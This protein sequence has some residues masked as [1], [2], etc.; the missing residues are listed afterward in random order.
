M[1]QMTRSERL[2]NMIESLVYG[3]TEV[4]DFVHKMAVDQMK[5]KYGWSQYITDVTIVYTQ[6]EYSEVMQRTTSMPVMEGTE[7]EK[8]YFSL[9]SD[10]LR[11]ALA[12]VID[13]GACWDVERQQIDV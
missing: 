11:K 10:F 9:M 7:K 6:G 12:K 8:M 4:G 3:D 1:T 2:A 5:I 13:N